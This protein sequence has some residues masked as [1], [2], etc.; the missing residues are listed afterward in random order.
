MDWYEFPPFG[1]LHPSLYAPQGIME[2]SVWDI[3]QKGVKWNNR[4]MKRQ[5]RGCVVRRPFFFQNM[6]GSYPSGR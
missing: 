4:G 5:G 2:Q 6:T 1:W 3:E